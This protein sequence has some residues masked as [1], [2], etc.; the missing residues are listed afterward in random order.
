MTGAAQGIGRAIALRLAGDGLDIVVN[1]ISSKAPHLDALAAEIT[2]SHA[3]RSLAVVGDMSQ[4]QDVVRLV[5]DAVE[6]LGG[7]DVVGRQSH[8]GG[9]DYNN[10]VIGIE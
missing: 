3:R 1:D 4:E 8:S 10:C 2:S 7:L 9:I 5:N 6:S